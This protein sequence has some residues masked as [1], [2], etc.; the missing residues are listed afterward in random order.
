MSDR[1]QA[2]DF[3]KFPEKD[4][5]LLEKMGLKKLSDWYWGN[6]RLRRLRRKFR[7]Y[8]LR[9]DEEQW[10]LMTRKVRK[11]RGRNLVAKSD[12]WSL[13]SYLEQVIEQGLRQLAAMNHGWPPTTQDG[14][15]WTFEEWQAHLVGLADKLLL[16]RTLPDKVYEKWKV[17]E[18]FAPIQAAEAESIRLRTE[19]LTDLAAIW[20]HLWD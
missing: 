10:P 19:V 3:S 16:S 4:P 6:P 18:D 1:I 12:C 20:G 7:K 8:V 13:D 17:G 15:E 9:Q 11:E 14:R 5:N 2:I